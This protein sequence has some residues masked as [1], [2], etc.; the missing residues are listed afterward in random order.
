ME[1]LSKLSS[2]KIYCENIKESP[3]VQRVNDVVN[4]KVYQDINNLFIDKFDP[5]C[6]ILDEKDKD[7]YYVQRL[8]EIATDIDEK[9]DTN[10]LNYK[11]SS[12]VFKP[13]LIQYGLQTPNCLS[14]V[15]YLGD[16]YKVTPVI[17]IDSIKTKIIISQKKRDNIHILYRDG[18]F[19][20]LDEP[21]DESLDY[22]QGSYDD[23][24][25]CLVLNVKKLDV[26]ELG[27]QPLGKY[28]V[29]ELVELSNKVNLPIEENG[30]KKV[31]KQLYDE[32]YLY[33]LNQTN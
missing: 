5:T 27:L 13:S 19:T 24:K 33:Y 15:I 7:L 8:L 31:K 22:K 20:E 1:L 11:Y 18:T 12:K 4:T 14:S 6:N 3:Y 32:L 10:Y 17:Y 23:L 25:H 2:T 9:N 28:K 26:Y 29:T 16:F 21:L 30:K